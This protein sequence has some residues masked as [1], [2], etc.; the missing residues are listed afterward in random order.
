[1]WQFWYACWS[2]TA[3]A[4]Q[5]MVF[6]PMFFA[7]QLFSGPSLYSGLEVRVLEKAVGDYR[8]PACDSVMELARG[9]SS[10]A[11]IRSWMSCPRCGVSMLLAER[12][13]GT[14]DLSRQRKPRSR[15]RPAGE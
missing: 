8:C 6:G 5:S 9:K 7:G 2:T 4:T 3:V 15:C 1:M 12:I 13:L 11:P 14:Q 10:T